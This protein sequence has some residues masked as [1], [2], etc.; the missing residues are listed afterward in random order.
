MSRERFSE[1]AVF[2][3]LQQSLKRAVLY[4][5]SDQEDLIKWGQC[6]INV[7]P[8]FYNHGFIKNL[9]EINSLSERGKFTQIISHI[10]EQQWNEIRANIN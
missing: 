2:K 9:L 8:E 4:T 7:A 3:L 1:P 10:T 6:S 5:F